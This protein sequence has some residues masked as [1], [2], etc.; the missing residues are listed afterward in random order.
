VKKL[1]LLGLALALA[2][3]RGS[4]SEEPPIHIVP[5]MDWQPKYEP[6]G[7]S[8]YFADGRAM[9][10]QVE[11]TVARGQLKDD[12]AFYK[13]TRDG[14]F[15]AKAPTDE[16]Q[17]ALKVDSLE[18]LLH[19]GQQRFN[20][21]CAPCHDQT[22]SGKGLVV[23]HGYPLP[24]GLATPHPMSVGD[25]EIFS[26]ISNGVR[27]MPAYGHQIPEADRW[28]IVAWVRVIQ[29]S[30]HASLE[31]VPPEQRNA[32]DPEEAQQ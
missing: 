24:I 27:N 16:V 8:A 13:G 31:D 12:E 17:T 29:R 25:G 1:A 15:L 10:P 20:I 9:R 7:E 4:V 26:Y 18:K 3:C 6:Q 21:Y 19:R 22:G 2:A 30:Q 28:A 5:D 23:Q 11:G 14:Q 32:I